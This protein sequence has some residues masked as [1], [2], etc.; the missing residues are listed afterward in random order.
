MNMM[1]PRNYYDT[2]EIFG[3]DALINFKSDQ[4]DAIDSVIQST[5]R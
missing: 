4:K 1:K 5:K 3:M 2:Y